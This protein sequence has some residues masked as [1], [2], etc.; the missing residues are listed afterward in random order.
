MKFAHGLGV[1]QTFLIL[2]IIYFI[3]IGVVAPLVRLFAGDPLD[4]RLRDRASVWSAKPG[5]NLRLD[6]A[7]RLF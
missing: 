7:R 3:V 1:I 5:T 6:E 4:R 2:A